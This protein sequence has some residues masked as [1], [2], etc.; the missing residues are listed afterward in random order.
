MNDLSTLLN[1]LTDVPQFSANIQREFNN[2]KRNR[3]QFESLQKLE[4]FTSNELDTR[5]G[6]IKLMARLLR[7]AITDEDDP[8]EMHEVE[9]FGFWLESE[10]DLI[11]RIQYQNANANFS[12]T[13][14]FKAGGSDFSE[15]NTAEVRA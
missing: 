10:M 9:Q 5:P 11:S 6:N 2:P 12:L 13:E 14:H 4:R 1:L 15:G 7:S 3:E 8:L